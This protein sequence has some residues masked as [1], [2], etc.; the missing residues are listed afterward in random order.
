MGA[1][2]ASRSMSFCQFAFHLKMFGEEINW[3]RR[4]WN[5]TPIA[6]ST[7]LRQCGNGLLTNGVDGLER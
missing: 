6:V 2:F 7:I 4:A 1:A 3:K 5:W